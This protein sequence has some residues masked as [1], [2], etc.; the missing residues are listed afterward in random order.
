LAIFLCFF[1]AFLAFVGAQGLAALAAHGFA[2]LGAHG[3]FG[4]QGF[5][6]PSA[7]A[8][9]KASVAAISATDV[10]DSVLRNNVFMYFS[11]L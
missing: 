4:A 2:I 3:F 6:I 8:A 10:R 11:L 9:G 1:L 5:A 7:A